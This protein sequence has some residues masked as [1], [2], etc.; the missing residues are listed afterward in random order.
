M[1]LVGWGLVCLWGL[2]VCAFVFVVLGFV[3]FLKKNDFSSVTVIT[4][5]L[6]KVGINLF[7]PLT[8]SKR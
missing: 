6:I 4:V 3:L 1:W 7:K 2:F 8:D 5:F